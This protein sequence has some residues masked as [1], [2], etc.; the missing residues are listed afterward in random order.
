MVNTR[1]RKRLT[2]LP[3]VLP[4]ES[5]DRKYT[6]LV[7]LRRKFQML[8]F[9]YAFY[10]I[11][12]VIVL[13]EL[14]SRKPTLSSHAQFWRDSS[15]IMTLDGHTFLYQ[16]IF[17]L[18]YP[19]RLQPVLL[20]LRGHKSSSYD[21]R[22]VIS[23]FQKKFSRIIIPDLP[24]G[25]Y[26]KQAEM[27]EQLM[28]S[29]HVDHFH[30]LTHMGGERISGELFSTKLAS[31]IKSLCIINGGFSSPPFFTSSF[32]LKNFAKYSFGWY[33]FKYA[34]LLNFHL[35][36]DDLY[37]Q[38]LVLLHREGNWVETEIDGDL[39]SWHKFLTNISIPLR[40][41]YGSRDASIKTYVSTLNLTNYQVTLLESVGYYPQLEKP[42]LFVK[43]Y[44]KLFKNIF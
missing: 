15:Y 20:L 3:V 43:E 7:N 41:I 21:W 17:N 26:D 11:F 13:M 16:D 37:D 31:N 25:D 19:L 5:E 38:F 8:K 23:Y 12:L 27:I 24:G 22:K 36:A 33:L 30:L 6:T 34:N 42:E 14:N 39:K 9:R 1:N 28:I 29:L 4:A 2:Q 18:Q 40:L 44:F 10:L 32:F 35:S